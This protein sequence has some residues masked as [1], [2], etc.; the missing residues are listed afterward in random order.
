MA[1]RAR[2]ARLSE[3]G[4]GMAGALRRIIAAITLCVAAL[5][6]FAAAVGLFLICL[7]GFALLIAGISS[8]LQRVD[9]AAAW[10]RT[11]GGIGLIGGSAGLAALGWLAVE[12]LAGPLRRVARL[13]NRAPRAAPERETTLQRARKF[14]AIVGILLALIC[15]P[16]A[17]AIHATTRAPWLGW[18]V[19]PHR[20][21]I[22]APGEPRLTLRGLRPRSSQA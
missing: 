8:W 19:A 20:R 2:H 6:V 9:V 17:A 3:H 11:L 4:N 1:P 10:A 5:V 7:A 14:V 16:F 12:R 21:I 13:R 18:G 22:R 15:L